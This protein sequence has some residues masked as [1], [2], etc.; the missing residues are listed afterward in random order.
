MNWERIFMGAVYDPFFWVAERAG[1]ARRRRRVL[2]AASGRVLEIGAGTGLNAS[3]WPAAVDELIVTEPIAEL[4]PRVERRLRRAGR[5]ARVVAAPA[6]ALPVA[7]ASVDT[8][9]STMV[10]C[11]VPDVAAA[12]AEIR[13]VLRPGGRLVF[14]EHVRAEHALRARAQDL[15]FRPWHAVGGGCRCNQDTL[16]L[17]RAAGFEV[18]DV[19]RERWRAMP[20]PVKP[21]ALG[22]AW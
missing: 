18:G 11:T 2:A 14:L 4:L 7:D 17:L 3:H 19:R 12:L 22:Q 5:E 20:F 21:L 16:G 9:V 15:V 1:M 13:R 10:L 6:E 8:V